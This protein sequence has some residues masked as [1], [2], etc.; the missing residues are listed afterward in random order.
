MGRGV[1]NGLGVRRRDRCLT[2]LTYLKL[3]CMVI[4]S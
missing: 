2:I 3:S 1:E 4:E